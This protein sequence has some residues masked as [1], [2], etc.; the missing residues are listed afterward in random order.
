VPVAVFLT[1]TFAFSWT[2]AAAL[3]QAGGLAG[4]GPIAAVYVVA[5]MFGPAVG[6]LAATVLF[7]RARPLT[8]LSLRPIR[9]RAVILWSLIGWLLAVLLCVGGLA[10]TLL[11]GADAPVVAA[12]RLAEAARAAGVDSLPFSP[13]TLLL[14]TLLV[15]VPVGIVINTVLLTINEELGWR[16]WLQ[17]MHRKRH[18]LRSRVRSP[19]QQHDSPAR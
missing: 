18:R 12:M 5:F 16:G 10:A 6:A 14:I 7:D 8:A 19:A 15:N 9:W 17:R 13:R 3:H 4:A 2:I 11:V 1:V